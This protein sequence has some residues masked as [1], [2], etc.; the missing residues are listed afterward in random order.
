[1]KMPA[2]GILCAVLCVLPLASQDLPEWVQQIAA[3]KQQEGRNLASIPNYVCSETV[4]RSAKGAKSRSFYNLDTLHFDVA[5]VGNRDLLAL[6]GASK[7]EDV[8]LSHFFSSGLLATGE[9]SATANNLFTANSARFTPHPK[10]DAILQ[11]AL[12]F[13]YE[14]PVFLS[15]WNISAGSHSAMVGSR[16]TIWVDP[17]S[18]ELK[19]IEERAVDIPGVLGMSAIDV[20]IDYWR[21]QIGSSLVRLP[22]NAEMVVTDLAGGAQRNVIEFSGCREFTADS[23]IKFDTLTEPPPKKK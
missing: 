6:P 8:S 7:F 5:H 16:G 19:R 12:G 2:A 20:S 14:I 18:L 15:A 1:M 10:G 11:L 23:T 13:D 9:F 4:Y 3:I 22:N 21:M 17:H